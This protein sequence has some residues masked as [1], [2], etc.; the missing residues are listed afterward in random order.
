MRLVFFI[1]F[2]FSCSL[3]LLYFFGL[4][5]YIVFSGGKSPHKYCEIIIIPVS[6]HL[7]DV[8]FLVRKNLNMLKCEKFFQKQELIFL[9]GGLDYETRT[10]LD[11]LCRAYNFTICEKGEIYDVMKKKLEKI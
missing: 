9:D 7:E 1:I 6:G 8:E 2:A 10:I 11:R 4:L 3:G 5:K